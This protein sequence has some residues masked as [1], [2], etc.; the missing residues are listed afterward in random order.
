MANSS[1]EHGGSNISL[2]NGGGYAPVSRVSDGS[3]AALPALVHVGRAVNLSSSL[4]ILWLEASI[5]ADGLIHMYVAAGLVDGPSHL[6]SSLL[7]SAP[8]QTTSLSAIFSSEAQVRG[9][10]SVFELWFC[11]RVP[12]ISMKAGSRMDSPE[13]GLDPEH[14]VRVANPGL[15]F[16]PEGGGGG[17]D[18][19]GWRCT[20]G[21]E[22]SSE[23]LSQTTTRQR[24]HLLFGIA[25]SEVTKIRWYKHKYIQTQVQYVFKAGTSHPNKEPSNLAGWFS[26]CFLR[27]STDKRP[28]SAIRR[29]LRI[30]RRRRLPLSGSQAPRRKAEAHETLWAL[31]PTSSSRKKNGAIRQET[32][33]G[34]AARVERVRTHV[35]ICG[36][37]R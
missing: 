29:L 20:S 1:F 37:A 17:A 15:Q 11:L 16:C 9:H 10:P 19:D 5:R 8:L 12:G 7:A 3:A 14:R 26:R 25:H 13:D 27:N 35:P 6:Y 30:C 21:V 4:L 28:H 23:L 32:G 18:A 36:Y 22:V 2:R 33:G 34:A 24:S 31:R